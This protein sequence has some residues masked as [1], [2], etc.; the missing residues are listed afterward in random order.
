MTTMAVLFTICL[1]A[2]SPTV[3]NVESCE[4]HQ[5][6][7]YAG[8]QLTPMACLSQSIA[9]VAKWMVDHN[10]NSNEWKVTRIRCKRLNQSN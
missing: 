8:H 5:I 3:S 1:D 6:P 7:L 9:N 10:M 2:S 4:D